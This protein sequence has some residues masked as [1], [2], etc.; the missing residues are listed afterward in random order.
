MTEGNV[1]AL[2][3]Q[4][5]HLAANW[6]AAAGDSLWVSAWAT[7]DRDTE[8]VALVTQIVG[9]LGQ[10][11]ADSFDRERWYAANALVRQIVEAHY[12]MAV[13]RDDP[14]QRQRW[15]DASTNRIEKSFRPSQM[16]QAGRFRPSEYKQHCEWGGHPNPSARWLLP[17]HTGNVEPSTLSADLALHLT[18]TVDLLAG[19]LMMIPNAEALIPQLPPQGDLPALYRA[20]SAVDPF[21]RRM[22]LPP[23]PADLARIQNLRSGAASG[24]IT[25]SADAVTAPE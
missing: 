16:R 12:L 24:P 9:Q 17:N 5:S 10:T 20:W 2:R 4:V 25:A 22:Q 23:T 18:E 11:A 3:S 8:A 13:F 7:K 15:L 6:L 21:S 19:V 14:P 1:H